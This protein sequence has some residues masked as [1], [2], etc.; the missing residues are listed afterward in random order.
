MSTNLT[1]AQRITL[2][3]M[4]GHILRQ[5][6]YCAPATGATF[7]CY[8]CLLARQAYR[9]FPTQYAKAL[10]TVKGVRPL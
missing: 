5:E 7:T 2:E 9:D 6:C 3:H 8:R 10:Q 1:I 4:I